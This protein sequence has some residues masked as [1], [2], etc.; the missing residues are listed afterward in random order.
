M[1]T[2]SFDGFAANTLTVTG[3]IGLRPR[4]TM[5]S[6]C[7]PS[8]MVVV[9]IG[10]TMTVCTSWSSTVKLTT[11]EAIAAAAS[12]IVIDPASSRASL[13][14]S[15]PAVTVTSQPVVIAAAPLSEQLVGDTVTFADDGVTFTVM[16]AVG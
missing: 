2:V 9:V 8:A 7:P 5:K 10:V 12:E 11:L 16:A 3:E 1:L 6:W 4:L 14:D 13:D 15:V